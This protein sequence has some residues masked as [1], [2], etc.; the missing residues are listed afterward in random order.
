M[1]KFEEVLGW[2]FLAI[3]LSFCIT[4]V[5][6]TAKAKVIVL[7][8]KNTVAM[9]QVFTGA[10][11]AKVQQEAFNKAEKLDSKERLYLYLRTPGGSIDAGMSLIDSLNAL[12]IPVDTITSFAAS[13]GYNTVQLVNGKRYITPSGIL[14]SHRAYGGFEG[15]IPGELNTQLSFFMNLM[16]QKDTKIAKR[17][18]LTLDQYQTLVWNEYWVSGSA[19]IQQEQADEIVE[20]RCDKSLMGTTDETFFTFFGPVNVT[21]SNCPVINA[22]LK[23]K[24]DELKLNPLNVF[25]REKYDEIASFFNLMSNDLSMFT[26]TYIKTNKFKQILR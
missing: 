17:V 13:M 6:Q 5:S 14:M 25:E 12:S 4:L 20:V 18:G 10:S 23:I 16:D 19:A 3:V 21:F 1:K 11:V 24:L 8:N 22:P 9:R 15:Q 26:K 2:I 7:T